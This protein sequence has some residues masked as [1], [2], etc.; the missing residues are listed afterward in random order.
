MKNKHTHYLFIVFGLSL[1]M[2]GCTKQATLK[3]FQTICNPV[4]LS[5]MFQPEGVSY[6]EGA[7]PTV[8]LYQDEY[9]A[10]VSHSG[11]YFHS[12]DLIHWDLIVPN[13]V[14]PVGVFAPSAVIIGDTI[15]LVA[16]QVRQVVKT[17]DPKLGKWEVANP[18]F[19]VIYSDPAV[20]SDEDGRLYYYG[21]CSSVYPIMGYELDPKT[22]EP[23]SEGVPLVIAHKNQLGWEEKND[24]S[25]PNDKINPHIEGAWMNKYQGKY[26]LQ[27]ANPGTELKSYND[28]VYVS[29]KPLGPFTLAQ[30]NPFSYKPEGFAC[31]AGH[32]S[33]FQDKYGNYWHI[34]TVTVSVRHP[35]ERRLS[36]FP[37]FFDK[38]GEIYAYTGFG[39]YPLII[40]NKKI[41]SPE[42]LFPDWMLLSYKKKVEVSSTLPEYSITYDWVWKS[43]ECIVNSKAENMNDEEIRTWWSAA[44]GNDTEWFKMD[45]GN[46]SDV[47]AVQINFA[48]EGAQSFGRSAGIYYQYTI[49]SS[50]DGKDW[51]LLVDKS[52]NTIDAPHDYMQPDQP[53]KA[54]YLRV[55]NVS[56]PSG[57]FSVSDFRVFGKSDIKA[58]ETVS[59]FTAERDTD[60]RTVNL[61]WQPIKGAT[62]YNIRYG[63]RK[64]KLYL[65]YMVYGTT[66]LSIHSLNAEQEYFFAIDAFNEGGITRGQTIRAI[67]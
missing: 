54:Q 3:P 20:F 34:A 22:F 6:R 56:V 64:D 30:H 60:L 47:Y 21:G 42:E 35:F 52:R 19:K 8:I 25:T 44:T 26:Y 37:L 7:D 67:K 14:F 66:E 38:D 36:L 46:V 65:N 9:Y 5:Y 23:L 33:T 61:S 41:N 39:D 18:D 62:G 53:V 57:N 13:E 45:L 51:T 4:N 10:F 24:Y 12:T 55:K 32:G 58:P 40:P 15:Y 28:A 1:W 59:S 11:G 16:S 50:V 49:E 27:Y 2:S 17:S 31:G 48:D 43:S 29:D 63:S